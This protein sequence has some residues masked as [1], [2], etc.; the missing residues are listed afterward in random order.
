MG[1]LAHS[2]HVLRAVVRQEHDLPYFE[3]EKPSQAAEKLCL[4]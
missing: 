2:T 4:E 1:A 3:L